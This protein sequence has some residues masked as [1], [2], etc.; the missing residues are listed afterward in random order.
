MNWYNL[1]FYHI[2]VRYYKNGKY[3]NDIPWLT[4]SVLVGVCSY[5]YFL[6]VILLGYFFFISK[7]APLLENF[8]TAIIG[9]GFVFVIINYFWFTY[10]K[11]YLK[12]F[13]E[14][15]TSNNS[16]RVTEILSWIYLIVGF[17]SVPIAAL[18]IR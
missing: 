11:R 15:K 7:N 6:N 16:N 14:Y 17:A 8:R 3:K 13:K 9:G 10:K 18:I 1:V 5:F 12:I 4:V 2:F